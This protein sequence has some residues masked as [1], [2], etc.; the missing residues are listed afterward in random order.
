MSRTHGLVATYRDGCRCD[1]CRVAANLKRA[2][3]RRARREQIE[4]EGIPEAIPH[5]RTGYA[6][7]GCRCGVCKAA[8]AEIYQRR[9]NAPREEVPHGPSGYVNWGCKCDTCR[10]ANPRRVRRAARGVSAR[11]AA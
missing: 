8:S 9:R 6:N 4:R 7:W 2:L 10:A 3:Q 11:E 5:G 1:D